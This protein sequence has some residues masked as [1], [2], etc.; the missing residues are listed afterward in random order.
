MSTLEGAN[1]G[2][3]WLGAG[4]LTMVDEDAKQIHIEYYQSNSGMTTLF[5]PAV[6]KVPGY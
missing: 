5:I 3:H 4:W 6:N 2:Q 1:L